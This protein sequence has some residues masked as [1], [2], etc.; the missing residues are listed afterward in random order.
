MLAYEALDDKEAISASPASFYRVMRDEDLAGPRSTSRD[1]STRSG[2]PPREEIDG[3][4]QRICWDISYIHTHQRHRY[5]YLYTVLDEWSRKVLAWC[6]KHNR[7]KL[8]AE[9][10]LN[11]LYFKENL[12]ERA[13]EDMPVVIND[14]GSQ[15]KAKSVQQMFEDMG[16]DQFFTR[17]HTPNDNPFVEALFKTVKYHPEYPNKFRVL[18]EAQTYFDLYFQWYNTEHLHSSIGYITP[19]DKHN[20]L[21]E[22]IQKMRK[23]R[24]KEARQ[25]RIRKHTNQQKANTEKKKSL[26]NQE[27]ELECVV[28]A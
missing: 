7:K 15:M 23:R 9:K 18:Q 13:D 17:P 27:N 1:T 2:K 20:G 26:E 14:N 5:F 3:P 25:E 22:S 10:M 28:R 24:L 11:E 6:I 16:I 8:H 4:L 21:G 19:S 12:M